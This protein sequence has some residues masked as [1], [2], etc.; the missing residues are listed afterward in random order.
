MGQMPFPGESGDQILC[1]SKNDLV[2]HLI[3]CSLVCL[4]TYLFVYLCGHGNQKYSLSHLQVVRQ[5]TG[6]RVPPESLLG[7]QM[8]EVTLVKSGIYSY[9]YAHT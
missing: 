4:L 5:V 8:Q 7:I 9:R 2:I 6:T 1:I 3:D